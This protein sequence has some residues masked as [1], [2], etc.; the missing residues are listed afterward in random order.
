MV[1]VSRFKL[2]VDKLA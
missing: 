2:Y 1:L